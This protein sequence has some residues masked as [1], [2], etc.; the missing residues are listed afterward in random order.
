MRKVVT[1]NEIKKYFF[2]GMSLMVG[3][4]MGCGT[5]EGLVDLVLELGIKD[6]T[7]I[8]TDTATTER[9]VGRLIAAKRIK[10]LYA[11]HIGL[12]PE[13]GRQMHDGTIEVEL[14]PQGSLAEKIRAG[15]FGLGGILTPTG[16]GTVV[17]EGK[18]IIEV[19]GVKFILEK[20]L[21]ADVSLIRG[22]TT[23]FYGNV[24]YGGTSNN[25]NQVM[26]TAGNIVIVETEK[27]VPAGSLNKESIHTQSIFVDYIIKGGGSNVY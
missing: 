8:A 1:K 12:N 9:G 2:D 26:A 11:S 19:D 3:G 10:K 24:I 6:I 15:G 25:F 7:L 23:D 4:F 16:I 21:K 17:E 18:Q 13:T 14:V 20:P 27:L 5:P 22:S